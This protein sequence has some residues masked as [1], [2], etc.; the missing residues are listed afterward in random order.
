MQ[1]LKEFLRQHRIGISINRE[2]WP[3]VAVFAFVTLILW[4]LWSPLGWVGV[5]LTLW[6]LWFFRDPERSTPIRN[7]LIISPADGVICAVGMGLFFISTAM[8]YNIYN[9]LRQKNLAKALFSQNG[10]A[11]FVFYWAVVIGVLATLLTDVQ[12]MR[13]W[14]ILLLIVAPLLLIFAQEPLGKL[15]AHRKDWLPKE[16][17]GFVVESFFELFEILLS[18]LSNTVSFVRIGA[19]ALNHVGM[20][21]VVFALMESVG[22]AASPIIFVVGNLFVMC[23]EGLIV[24]IQV[25]R[26]E[27]YELFGRFYSGDGTPYK[28]FV[29]QFK[30]EKK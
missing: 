19:F 4:L 14:Y 30:R 1:A 12:L 24:G 21:M 18:F 6:C 16:K 28:P 2:G 27:F 9:G 22:G 5:I 3:F 29:V 17:G 10:L 25:L 15:V 20:M 11:G 26:L 23:L 13:P 8:I 7:G